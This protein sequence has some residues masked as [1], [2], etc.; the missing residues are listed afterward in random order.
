MLTNIKTIST[1]NSRLYNVLNGSR[2]LLAD[3]DA[4]IQIMEDSTDIE[5]VKGYKTKVYDYKVVI[6]VCNEIES[7]EPI[8]VDLLKKTESFDLELEIKLQD[9]T[10]KR[11]G[12]G[13]IIPKT[14]NL[15]GR[16]EFEI[17]NSKEV[18]DDLKRENLI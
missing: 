2:Y 18:I 6:V 7:K 16:W 5:I 13:N 9:G 15:N 3:C 10:Y 1:Q 11:M 14:I 4:D 8:T 12:L 17:A